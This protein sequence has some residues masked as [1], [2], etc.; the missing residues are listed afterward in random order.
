MAEDDEPSDGRR[1]SLGSR[2]TPQTHSRSRF[3]QV[4]AANRASPLVSFSKSLQGAR[5]NADALVVSAQNNEHVK[6]FKD[7]LEDFEHKLKL[8]A[9]EATAKL[10]SLKAQTSQNAIVTQDWHFPL[11]AGPRQPSGMRKS[12][13]ATDF[14]K[15]SQLLQSDSKVS[16]DCTTSKLS[17][18]WPSPVAD[19]MRTGTKYL[20]S[21]ILLQGRQLAAAEAG[22]QL[23]KIAHD[24]IEGPRNTLKSCQSTLGNCQENFQVLQTVLQQNLQP[25]L[26]L[27]KA[28]AE[29][30]APMGSHNT[31]F[32]TTARIQSPNSP[33]SY[34]LVPFK[35]H[36]LTPQEMA[37]DPWNILPGFSRA[38]ELAAI[39][40]A[41]EIKGNH[42][43]PS[44][45]QVGLQYQH[46]PALCCRISRHAPA[47]PS[48]TQLGYSAAERCFHYCKPVA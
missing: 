27:L 17:S 5:K 30:S 9:Q 38:Q 14:S 19:V 22:K 47:L 8:Q 45:P 40:K 7:N 43:Q 37:L 41:V 21:G 12:Y 35:D 11:A 3:S 2:L 20:T 24:L 28:K 16:I 34:Q 1:V 23:E 6:K 29:L 42:Q 26:P 13:S 15:F 33:S 48:S 44:H 10:N 4:Q 39:E 31:S 32:K 18:S 36:R 46:V 25:S